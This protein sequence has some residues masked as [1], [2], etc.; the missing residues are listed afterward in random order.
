ML[1]ICSLSHSRYV[2]YTHPRP[3]RYPFRRQSIVCPFMYS[4]ESSL[5][6]ATDADK[7]CSRARNHFDPSGNVHLEDT[8]T[9]N[10]EDQ[11]RTLESFKANYRGLH[12]D[13]ENLMYFSVR[14]F[15]WPESGCRLHLSA[16]VNL[17]LQS[18]EYYLMLRMSSLC[19]R[20]IYLD[21]S[22]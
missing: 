16:L 3:V 15:L 4:Y 13:Q 20:I 10:S 12:K 1:I 21:P 2:T 18:Y 11:S 7:V 5:N 14:I 6:F 17:P 9:I 19:S 22:S 8:A